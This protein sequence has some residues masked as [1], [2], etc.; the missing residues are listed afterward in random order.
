[1]PKDT[2][3]GRQGGS[4]ERPARFFADTGEFDAWLA[5]HHATETELWMGLYKKHVSERG[6]TWD[7][8]VPVALCW[9]WIDSV[10]QR[11]DEDTTRQRWTPRKR[12]SNWSRVNLE[13]V[14]Q[15]RTEGRMQPAGLAIWEQRKLEPAP[16]THEA[17]GE[18]VLPAAYAA[19]LAASPEA[20]AFLEAATKTYRR[21]CVNWV[22]SAKQEATRD[23]RMAQLVEDSAAGRLIPSQRYGEI[24]KWIERAAAAAAAAR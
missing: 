7:Q 20:T 13:L 8:A 23:R 21:I 19:Q 11:I 6:L 2:T 22:V 16:Y 18:L 4:A 1:M 14:E 10:V 24:P 17:D 15:L 9:G 3:P 5:A 12:T